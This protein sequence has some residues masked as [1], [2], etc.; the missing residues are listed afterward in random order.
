MCVRACIAWC[1]KEKLERMLLQNNTCAL[2]G[3]ASI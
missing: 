3:G 2:K 1:K